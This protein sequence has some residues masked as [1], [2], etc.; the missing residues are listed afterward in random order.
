MDITDFK[1]FYVDLNGDVKATLDSS[2]KAKFLTTMDKLDSEY[3]IA[4]NFDV[5]RNKVISINPSFD[6][7]KDMLLKQYSVKT[8]KE[9]DVKGIKVYYD[10]NKKEGDFNYTLIGYDITN[11]D[12]VID[13][14]FTAPISAVN[15]FI[16]N[17]GLVYEIKTFKTHSP[18]L[19]SIKRNVKNELI[20]FKTYYVLND[21]VDIYIENI[22]RHIKSYLKF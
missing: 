17:E 4:P 21:F 1:D 13:Y 12:Y 10:H 16:E 19:Y 18:F 15:E 3:L 5:L 11:S 2:S 20:N 9:S 6:L 22:I 8:N 14:Y 7:S